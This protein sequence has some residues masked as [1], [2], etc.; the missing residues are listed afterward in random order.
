MT[1]TIPPLDKK[2]KTACIYSNGDKI[3][4]EPLF[5]YCQYVPLPDSKRK[6]FNMSDVTTTELGQNVKEV[7]ENSR[8]LDFSEIDDFFDNDRIERDIC[9][10][11]KI[12]E[13]LFGKKNQT[14]LNKSMMQIPANI[15]N[16]LIK[17]RP[18]KH[19][20]SDYYCDVASNDN[21]VV[22]VPLSSSD[23]EI[24]EALKLAFT[25]CTGLGAYEFHKKLKELG[26][27]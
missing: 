11:E 10:C 14:T 7:F 9:E 12:M 18:T 21:A 22:I 25:R 15:N 20:R 13:K 23:E 24:G 26:W 6:I 16:G 2:D 3:L 5:G 17:L 8:V 27:E 19:Q 4:F 1:Q